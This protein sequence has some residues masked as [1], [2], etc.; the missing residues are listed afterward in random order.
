MKGKHMAAH[1]SKPRENKRRILLIGMDGLMPEQIDRYKDDIPE[2]K[3]F[4]DRGF[5][6][7]AHSSP[8]TC[9]ATNWP[10]IA[11][12]AWVGTHGCTSF[13]VHL[14]GMELGETTPSFNSQLCKAEYF[15]HAAERQGK[16]CILVNYPCAFPKVL[17]N[18]VVIGGDGLQSQAWTVRYPDRLHTH[19]DSKRRATSGRRSAEPATAVGHEINKNGEN[20]DHRS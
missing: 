8:Y 2:L 15:W 16:R 9:T 20:Y 11:T 10:T 6:S 17:K 14:P 12:G 13:N 5:F 1:R 18:G 7:P 19:N 4:L 3:A